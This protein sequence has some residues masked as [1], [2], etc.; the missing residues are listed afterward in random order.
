MN[1]IKTVICSV[2]DYSNYNNM[3][4]LEKSSI[5]DNKLI[6][7]SL[8]HGIYIQQRNIIDCS[9][10][11][12]VSFNKFLTAIQKLNNSEIS[13]FYLSGHGGIINGVYNFYF[14]DKP[15]PFSEIMEKIK[16][17]NSPIKIIFL[18]SCQSG[19]DIVENYFNSMD[20]NFEHENNDAYLF[21]ASSAIDELSSAF[22]DGSLFTKCLS[23]AIDD[24]LNKNKTHTLFNIVFLTYL[25]LKKRTNNQNCM[26]RTNIIGDVFF[27]NKYNMTPLMLGPTEPNE[28]DFKIEE[29]FEIEKR[30]IELYEVMKKTILNILAMKRM[31]MN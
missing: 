18:D 21:F 31:M 17:I 24:N 22:S 19:T 15:Y 7:E 26:L 30:L 4:T 11:T 20:Y 23:W 1:N 16:K 8:L 29:L 25:Y 14:S 9:Q 5:A 10:T 3:N 2:G 6:K 13:I 12:A 28:C 27:H